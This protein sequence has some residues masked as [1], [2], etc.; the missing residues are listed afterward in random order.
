MKRKI[1]DL[2]RRYVL[3]YSGSDAVGNTGK[4]HTRVIVVDAEQP[5]THLKLD[6]PVYRDRYSTFAVSRTLME[7]SAVDDHSGIKAIYYRVDGSPAKEYRGPF[8][9]Q[10]GGKHTL[11][12]YAVDMTNNSEKPLQMAFQIDNEPPTLQINY[13]VEPLKNSGDGEYTLH[14]RA[15][16]ELGEISK[17]GTY[18]FIVKTPWH[19]TF[20]FM[21]AQIIFIIMLLAAS[22]LLAGIG[23]APGMSEN[24]VIF[25]V[26][27]VFEYVNGVIGPLIGQYSDG[28]AFFGILMTGV[29]S[30]IISPAQEFVTKILNKITRVKSRLS[31]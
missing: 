18:T 5:Q 2:P 30:F 12:Y 7:L 13:N 11:T 19:E 24:L 15:K 22:R 16:N 1:S 21:A 31:L 20:W 4:I 14:V 6:G 10:A 23:I 28:I 26:V 17:E 8:S 29:L 27:I 25:V 3:T 9:I